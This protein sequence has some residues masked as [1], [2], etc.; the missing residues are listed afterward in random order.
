MGRKPIPAAHKRATRL[1]VLL[2][3]EEMESV[4][5]A[6]Q[7]AGAESAS[8]WVRSLILDKAKGASND[9]AE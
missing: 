3:K 2:T 4:E 8:A 1:V 7:S 5:A 9:P 6:W